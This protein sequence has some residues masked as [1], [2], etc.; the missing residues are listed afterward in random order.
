MA[1]RIINTYHPEGWKPITLIEDKHYLES[2][3]QK[4]I[5]V[6]VANQSYPTY[7]F[8]MI[9]VDNKKQ[10][11]LLRSQ[12]LTDTWK[13]R[14]QIEKPL[15]SRGSNLLTEILLFKEDELKKLIENGKVNPEYSFSRAD[16]I[17]GQDFAPYWIDTQSADYL[18]FMQKSLRDANHVNVWPVELSDFLNKGKPHDFDLDQFLDDQGLTLE[19][20]SVLIRTFF[21]LVNDQKNKTLS[22]IADS[23]EEWTKANSYLKFLYQLLPSQDRWKVS[24]STFEKDDSTFKPKLLIC[25]SAQYQKKYGHDQRN[26]AYFR[27]ANQEIKSDFANDKISEVCSS[28][29]DLLKNNQTSSFILARTLIDLSTDQ[30]IWP[31]ICTFF[32]EDFKSKENH[33]E[34]GVI[35]GLIL[36]LWKLFQMPQ[37]EKFKKDQHIKKMIE[38]RIIEF[39]I[40]SGLYAHKASVADQT[41]SV[42]KHKDLRH[43]L[44]DLATIFKDNPLEDARLYH[45][46]DETQLENI[47][48]KHEEAGDIF[49]YADKLL[50]SYTHRNMEDMYEAPKG[51]PQLNR[52][53]FSWTTLLI[54]CIEAINELKITKDIDELERMY[55]KDHADEEQNYNTIKNSS[56]LQNVI[57]KLK[58]D[59]YRSNSMDFKQC[60]LNDLLYDYP[61][62]PTFIY[63]LRNLTNNQFNIS[64]YHDL[65]I[66]LEK[67]F[68]HL[69]QEL[70]S[71]NTETKPLL[72]QQQQQ[73]TELL[74]YKSNNFGIDQQN[75]VEKHIHTLERNLAIINSNIGNYIQKYN[76]LSN[77][78]K[79]IEQESKQIEEVVNNRYTQISLYQNTSSKLDDYIKKNQVN[80]LRTNKKAFLVQYLQTTNTH[81]PTLFEIDTLLKFYSKPPLPLENVFKEQLEK[82]IKD[83][84]FVLDIPTRNE[85]LYKS[86]IDLYI[87][88]LKHLSTGLE[89]SKGDFPQIKRAIDQYYLF[90]RA[91]NDK[92]SKKHDP[93]KQQNPTISNSLYLGFMDELIDEL[94]SKDILNDHDKL[95]KFYISLIDHKLSK[96]HSKLPEI[97]KLMASDT[98][99]YDLFRT[100]LSLYLIKCIPD[101]LYPQDVNDQNDQMNVANFKEILSVYDQIDQQDILDKV[102]DTIENKAKE[103]F[104]SSNILLENTLKLL[105]VKKEI[106]NENRL[107]AYINTSTYLKYLFLSLLMWGVVIASFSSSL[108]LGYDYYTDPDL[109]QLNEKKHKNQNLKNIIEEKIK[110][111]EEEIAALEKIDDSQ[112]ES[113]AKLKDFYRFDKNKSCEISTEKGSFDTIIKLLLKE[114]ISASKLKAIL[115]KAPKFTVCLSS[116]KEQPCSP[117]QLDNPFLVQFNNTFE[118]GTLEEKIDRLNKICRIDTEYEAETDTTIPDSKKEEKIK[119]AE[120]GE[121]LCAKLINKNIINQIMFQIDVDYASCDREMLCK[122][123][124]DYKEK[125]ELCNG[126]QLA[127]V[128]L[129]DQSFNI[130]K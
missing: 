84:Y 37:M 9:L 26:H 19:S 96:K 21:V 22:L 124:T 44:F 73:N 45:L 105:D 17:V 88:T 113:S 48:E 75:L 90:V 109:E 14:D 82:L 126:D 107:P 34:R 31:S 32:K 54:E 12:R 129:C 66:I 85:E 51:I 77:T 91:D 118:L 86:T 59:S 4:A 106:S 52:R 29:L 28:L 97:F 62:L 122:S 83:K 102:N 93:S 87:E 103:N 1:S 80:D 70:E 114:K 64:T 49:D 55:F 69:H 125:E 100:R 58:E 81:Q 47:W 7:R 101:Y 78:L 71:V 111:T 57:N 110:K 119:K 36:E 65:K 16:V 116:N 46:L 25:T 68:N 38:D 35:E 24:F 27:V 20:L 43:I 115:L 108:Y 39:P 74:H 2:L 30:K 5:D 130:C 67:I 15:T 60:A 104:P 120:E 127:I 13:D 92:A 40:Y 18:Q 23:L 98:R 95:I 33:L 63:K 3:Q 8:G 121:I 6:N 76:N 53:R 117:S 61:N 112:T 42:V 99:L 56:P 41:T 89:L 94:L 10:F 11:R 72:S 128:K 50:K 79:E 123:L